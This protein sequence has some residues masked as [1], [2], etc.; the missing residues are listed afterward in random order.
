M[1]N[2]TVDCQKCGCSNVLG[3]IFCRNC[4]V[5]L[6]F[7]KSLLDTPRKKQTRKILKR[8]FNALIFILILGVI[9]MAFCP[10]GFPKTEKITDEQEIA[11]LTKICEDI[12]LLLD[13]NAGKI[14]YTF[15]P[16]EATFVANYL[17]SQHEIKRP[18]SFGSSGGIGSVGKMGSSS[19]LGGTGKMGE[20]TELGGTGKIDFDNS[21]VKDPGQAAPEDT[22]DDTPPE[23]S[24][25]RRRRRLA[26]KKEE[27]GKEKNLTFDFTVNLKGENTIILVLKEKWYDFIPCRLELQVVPELIKGEKKEDQKL[28]FNVTS[29]R[30]G[31][32]PLPLYLKEHILDL[33]KELMLT[34]R[35]WAVKYFKYLKNVEIENKEITVSFSK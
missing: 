23:D 15:T 34:E 28:N 21:S 22:D 5:K 20:R 31:Y 2:Q 27:K 14:K 16:A 4:G 25:S 33:F 30:F 11:A 10:V 29:A 32:L 12:D 17:A 9:G 24:R 26:E 3:T 7:N 6:K 18:K 35:E 19:E 1:Q 13:R 8:T